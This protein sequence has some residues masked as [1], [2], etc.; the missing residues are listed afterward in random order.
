MRWFNPDLIS[1]DRDMLG[2][3]YMSKF[4]ELWF[5]IKRRIFNPQTPQQNGNGVNK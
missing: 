4:I 2:V 5:D 3:C 1:C